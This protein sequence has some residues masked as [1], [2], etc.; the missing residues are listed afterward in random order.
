MPCYMCFVTN[1]VIASICVT[2]TVYDPR[3]QY[4]IEEYGHWVIARIL[5]VQAPVTTGGPR[6]SP[7]D[8]TS[9]QSDAALRAV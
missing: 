3:I 2:R 5:K 6:A 4:S 1:R 7:M 9:H 8:I